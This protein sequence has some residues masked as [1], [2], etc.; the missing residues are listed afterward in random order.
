MIFSTGNRNK[1]NE[2][3]LQQLVIQ[4]IQSKWYRKLVLSAAFASYLFPSVNLNKKQEGGKFFPQFLKKL[5]LLT[6]QVELYTFLYQEEDWVCNRRKFRMQSRNQR[7][8]PRK[9]SSAAVNRE[10]LQRII[11]MR[12]PFHMKIVRKS[13]EYHAKS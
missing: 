2:K 1:K 10:N 9:R 5:L 7:I 6:G 12:L 11:F 3:R 13:C 8:I 4:A